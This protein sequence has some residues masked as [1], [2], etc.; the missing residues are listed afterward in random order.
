MDLKKNILGIIPAGTGNGFRRTLKIPANPRKA[1]LGLFA[2]EP[3]QVDLGLI[4]GSYFLNV[5][6]F[7]LDAAVAKLATVDNKVLRG[8]PAYVTAFL[9]KLATFESFPAT[10]TCDDTT[11]EERDILLAVISNG[12]Y[13]GGQLCIAPQARIDDG[14]LDLCLVRKTGYVPTTALAVKVFFRK[15]LGHKTICSASCTEVFVNAPESI[16]VHI[17]GEVCGSLPAKVGV[18][19]RALGILAPAE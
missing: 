1:L 13:Y 16:P 15:H 14:L 9:A 6:G 19:P 10:L 17:D 2:W 3:R 11:V 4:N 18:R 8:Y 7:G 5:V 12:R